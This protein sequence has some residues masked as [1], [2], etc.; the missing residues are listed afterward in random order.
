MI[1]GNQITQ[2]QLSNL[3][4]QLLQNKDQTT[5]PFILIA[6]PA[7]I[8]KSSMIQQ[9]ITKADLHG[10]DVVTLQDLSDI[11]WVLKDKNDLAGTSH[12]IQIDVETKRQD[13]K[14]PDSS[15][16]HNWG[17]RELQDRLVRSPLWS[18]KV[19][20]IEALERATGG[21]SNALL[22][23]LEEP[24]PHRLIIATTHHISQLPETIIS[25]AM[26]FHMDRLT[27][28]QMLTWISWYKPDIDHSTRD[29]I[30]DLAAGK[31]GIIVHY[32][33]LGLLDGLLTSWKSLQ[34]QML[35][36][37]IAQ[38]YQQMSTINKSGYLPIITDALVTFAQQWDKQALYDATLDL[39]VKQE[40]N[41]NI[42]NLLFQWCLRITDISKK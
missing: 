20:I 13:I 3:I 37:T 34:W 21:A 31:P 10:H 40:S 19:V 38:L 35:T 22:K 12:S 25:R 2:N 5:Y 9:I 6:G 28:E 36:W 32:D 8:G 23:T 29:L 15:I 42:E 4:S 7:H 30:L 17:V 39:L 16:V 26:V 11:W 41:V 27:H 1:Y 24:L 14:L 18:D 33:A